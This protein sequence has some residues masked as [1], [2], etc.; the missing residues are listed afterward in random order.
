MS[1]HIPKEFVFVSHVYIG[2]CITE[3]EKGVH[4][5]SS[6][7]DIN[8]FAGFLISENFSVNVKA[9]DKIFKL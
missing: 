9:Y 5:L 8:G 2:F 1:S 3:V 7:V 6:Y 4:P